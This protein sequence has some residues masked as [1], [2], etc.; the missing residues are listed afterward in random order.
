[1]YLYI[2]ELL[3]YLEDEDQ[4]L[5]A[6]AIDAICPVIPFVDDDT[7]TKYLLPQLLPFLDFKIHTTHE[8][9]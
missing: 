2:P 4:Q 3:G 6:D 9:T 8:I 5:V 7:I 1:M